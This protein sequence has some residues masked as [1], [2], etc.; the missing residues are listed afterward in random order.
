VPY[1]LPLSLWIGGLMLYFAVPVSELRWRLYPSHP[2]FIQIGK[3]LTFV[4]FGIFQSIVTGTVVHYVLGL[5]I[6]KPL[7]YYLF[8]LC[9]SFMSIAII[10]ALITILGSGPGRL[11]AIILLVL[12]LVSS[13]GTF[14]VDLIPHVFQVISP[15]LPMSYG[16]T[17]FRHII[18]YLQPK[19]LAIP[20]MMILLY[21]MV[22]LI[23]TF[24][25]QRRKFCIS[26]LQERDQLEAS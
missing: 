24:L 17:G 13:G 26:E 12:Q 9:I 5:P 2:W 25:G 14:P 11:V 23:C 4:P 15:L 22:S 20:F 19:E 6:K 10:G 1:F 16:V 18:V 8:L 3:L 21:L 7:Y